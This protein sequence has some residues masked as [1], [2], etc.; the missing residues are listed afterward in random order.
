MRTLNYVTWEEDGAFVAQCLDT[1]QLTTLKREGWP[2]AAERIIWN[3]DR[4]IG[5][6]SAPSG[7]SIP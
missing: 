3:A 5:V 2:T 4:L 6:L 1:D 7:V